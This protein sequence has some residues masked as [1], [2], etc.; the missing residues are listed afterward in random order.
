M[1][2]TPAEAFAAWCAFLDPT[3]GGFSDDPS[4]PGNWSSGRPGLGTLRGTKFGIACSSHPN[5]DIANL[6]LEQADEIR[7]V[8]YWDAVVGDQMHPSIAFLAAEAAYQSGPLTAR[9]QLQVLLGVPSDGVF[10]PRTLGT[11]ALAAVRDL[12]GLLAEFSARRLIFESGL[13]NWSLD[14]GGWTRRLFHGLLIARAL[15]GDAVVAQ[16]A[17]AVQVPLSPEPIIPSKG[18]STEGDPADTGADDLNADE[19]A[20]VRQAS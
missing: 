1:T 8:E 5:L 10:G 15:A 11:A 3:E 6:T 14:R 19:L 9:K 20:R 17:P 7:R 18:D 13:G 12:D 2:A 16:P 4:D